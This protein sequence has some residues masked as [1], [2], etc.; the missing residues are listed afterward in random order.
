MKTNEEIQEAIVS[1][2]KTLTDVT[3]L[4]A[5]G[6]DEVR[7]DTWQ[8]TE[9]KYPHVR[10]NLI[11]NVPLDATCNLCR[12]AVSFMVFAESPSSKQSDTIAGVLH[13]TLH[14]RSFNSNSITFSARTV[15][16]IPAV[17]RDARTWMSEVMM[18][19]LAAG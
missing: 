10:V 13:K 4:L 14:E 15:R 1:Y 9:F 3:S 8:G 2:T 11:D 5:D 18:S 16:L 6:A 12:V 17:R 7:E 19:M